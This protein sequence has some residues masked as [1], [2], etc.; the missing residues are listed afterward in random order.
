MQLHYNYTHDVML[1][2]L[3]AIHLLK[4]DKWHYEKNWT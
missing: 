4:Y 1:A 2:S 3:I